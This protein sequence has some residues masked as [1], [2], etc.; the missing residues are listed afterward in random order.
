MARQ[1]QLVPCI[2]EYDRPCKPEEGIHMK[3]LKLLLCAIF[4]VTGTG[5]AFGTAIEITGLSGSHAVD[6]IVGTPQP[7]P[8]TLIGDISNDD[9]LYVWNEIQS[10]V[11]PNNLYVDRVADSHASYIGGTAGG[12]YIKAGT[13]V[14]SHYIQWDPLAGLYSPK[15][16]KAT[17][18]LDT[19][20]IAF[21]TS[22]NRLFAS[23]AWL[24]APDINY[25]NFTLRGLEAYDQDQTIF[26]PSGDVSIIWTASTPGDWSRLITLV[27]PTPAPV[28]EPA[29]M[30]LFG[31]G[32]VGLL[33]V[34]KRFRKCWNG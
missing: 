29:T 30:L 8:F 15:T 14:S 13:V 12:Y 24:G 20:A 11:L 22:D 28:P 3:K 23:D 18:H 17:I 34:R 7:P 9:K 25:G 31:A 10:F 5:T 1:L 4:L 19:D 2:D 16:V 21:I 27:S 26:D 6:Y 33:G 32:L